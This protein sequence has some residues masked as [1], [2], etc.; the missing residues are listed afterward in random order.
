MTSRRAR[1]AQITAARQ[2]R[3]QELLVRLGYS[4]L[5][6]A[7]DP[8]QTLC[9]M[10]MLDPPRDL[11]TM[12]EVS[13]EIIDD[14]SLSK[15]E[16]ALAAWTLAVVALRSAPDLADDALDVTEALCPALAQPLGL[17]GWR[18]LIERR[19]ERLRQLAA[20]EEAGSRKGR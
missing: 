16:R 7:P 15:K 10:A 13:R 6:G 17:R 18:R 11:P 20:G 8:M 19:R 3:H 4:A 1:H 5:A 9:V 14:E 2:L 12:L